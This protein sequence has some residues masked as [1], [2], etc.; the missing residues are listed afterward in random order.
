MQIKGQ[1]IVSSH[2]TLLAECYHVSFPRVQQKRVLIWTYR[3]LPHFILTVWAWGCFY[4]SLWGTSNLDS[5][6][7]DMPWSVED[8]LGQSFSPAHRPLP[9]YCTLPETVPLV[10]RPAIGTYDSPT[11]LLKQRTSRD[12]TSQAT[13]HLEDKY[14]SRFSLLPYSLSHLWCRSCKKL[15]R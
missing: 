11:P 14:S 7:L 4:Y 2:D 10:L 12:G 3:T 13:K 15:S 1:K 6:S 8:L 5:G 9:W